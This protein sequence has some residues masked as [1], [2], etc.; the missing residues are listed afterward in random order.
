MSNPP[1][2]GFVT[3]RIEKIRREDQIGERGVAQG[4]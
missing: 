4:D 2:K 1:A 3:I